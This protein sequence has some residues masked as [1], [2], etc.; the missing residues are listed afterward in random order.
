MISKRRIVANGVLEGRGD[1]QSTSCIFF[2]VIL[3][4]AP[5]HIYAY[6]ERIGKAADDVGRELAS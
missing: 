5:K 3:V 4:F 1:V 2:S 6:D